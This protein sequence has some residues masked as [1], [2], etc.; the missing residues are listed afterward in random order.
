MSKT[1]SKTNKNKKT[2]G[3]PAVTPVR[4]SAPP[5]ALPEPGG[6][7]PT[8][9][10]DETPCASKEDAV[11]VFQRVRDFSNGLG[12][13]PQCRDLL[14]PYNRY[15]CLGAFQNYSE[16]KIQNA[17]RNY[18]WHVKGR[19]GPGFKPPPVYGS[20][21]GFLEKGV[22]RYEDDKALD[23]Q[24]KEPEGRNGRR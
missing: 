15:D 2:E 6:A 17:L 22:P 1:Q 12:C 10:P 9:G 11:A 3:E 14:I 24:F 20:L 4:L 19:C 8:D 5:P 13:L 21:Y 16:L 18:D 7:D 23:L